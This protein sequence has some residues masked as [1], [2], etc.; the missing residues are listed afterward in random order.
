V[1]NTNSLI[2]LQSPFYPNEYLSNLDCNCSM[3]TARDSS[4]QIEL[5][6]FDLESSSNDNGNSLALQNV[7]SMQS[8]AAAG[9][10]QS[11][12][13]IDN[14]NA[15]K[16]AGLESAMNIARTPYSIK[17]SK[18][19]KASKSSLLN[20]CTRDYFSINSNLQMCGAVSPFSGLLNLPASN[21]NSSKN[22][23]NNNKH[24]VSSF[25]FYSDD[26]LTR[27]GFWLKIKVSNLSPRDCP[28]N[29]ILVN[30]ICVR[31]YNEQ[32]TWYE[33]HTYCTS[34]GYSLALID[35]FELEKQLNKVLFND[36]DDSV[37]G[38]LYQAANGEGSGKVGGAKQTSGMK[39]FWIGMRHLNHTNW[40]D[41]KNEMIKFRADEANWWPWLI[42]D[43]AS[44]TQGSC[45]SKR[46]NSFAMED[47]YKRMPFACEYKIPAVKLERKSSVE[48]KCGAN[49]H[50][51]IDPV[52]IGSDLTT[53]Q[54]KTVDSSASDVET[55]TVK[56]TP[57][58][59]V[60]KTSQPL[61][62]NAVNSDLNNLPTT[63]I[64]HRVDDHGQFN[65]LPVKNS[66][67]L[68]KSN[69]S[70]K[71]CVQFETS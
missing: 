12:S 66:V 17:E 5:L 53:S 57:I 47:C 38:S 11:N 41:S 25:R 50:I 42:V 48:M 1:D 30:N 63:P 36:E 68:A 15:I 32:L 70:C 33:A 22:N 19:L 31:I 58:L 8:G 4:I 18:Q 54:T 21:N 49:A 45:V 2:Y 59:T 44:Y 27:R 60:L 46:R 13:N 61:G 69:D 39:R 35:N 6:E 43:S 14:F 26:A 56:P 3:R 71:L 55:E 23:N 62:G 51:F 40:F 37:I 10:G 29:F 64:K 52:S 28:D 65:N 67:V 9:G 7:N 16:L 20:S 24:Q 34:M